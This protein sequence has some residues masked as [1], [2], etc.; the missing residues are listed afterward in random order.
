VL[1]SGLRVGLLPKGTRGK[2]VQA[3]LALHLGDEKSLF[4]QETIAAMMGATLDK[5]AQGLSR[6]QISDAFDKLRA[7]VG[8]AMNGQTLNVSIT[9]VRDNLPA[10]ITLVGRILRNPT[11]P[12]DAFEEARSQWLTGIES[13]RKEPGAVVA[14]AL[15][16]HGNPYRK[17]DPRYV[18]TFEEQEADV[19]AVQVAQVQAFHKRFVSAARSEFAAV[20]DLDASAVNAALDKAFADWQAPAAGALPYV[21]VANPLV[22]VPP[23]RLMLPAPDKQNANLH[24]VL[25]L[26]VNDNHADYAALMTANY[27]FG[28]GGNSRLWKR[29]REKEGFSYDVRSSIEWSSED[30]NSTWTST[31]IFAPQ[32]QAKVEAA[33]REELALSLNGGF[34]AA[35]L[36][37]ARQ[38]L[39]ASRRLSRSQDA[40][41]A[42]QL[43]YNLYLQ[44][45][46]AVSQKTDDALA[47]LTL[48]QVNAVWKKY[49]TADKLAVAW[50]G[51]FKAP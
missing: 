43:Q 19:K 3:R 10:A 36:A 45:R 26:G 17:G 31:A 28:G 46:F 42:Y 18:S 16:R 24:V 34:T 48:D 51:D 27:M 11:F 37:D 29:L 21:R 32:N 30:L 23:V 39:L 35:E 8:F 25:P 47:K 13:Q 22:V 7:E 6:Q 44:R 38:G 50:G 20:G 40:N 14:N 2:A 5:G 15:E 33:W 12:K 4:N 9:T 41:V 1:A 49:I